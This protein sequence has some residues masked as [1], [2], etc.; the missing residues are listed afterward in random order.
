[1]VHP[2]T[3]LDPSLLV[4]TANSLKAIAH[5]VRLAMVELLKD[6][7]KLT[8]TE[9]YESLGLEQAVTSQH[10]SIL[11]DKNIL[12]SQRKGKHTFYSLKHPCVVDV[13][14]MILNT[15]ADDN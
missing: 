1:M 15:H 13:I 10:L 6:G 8:V 11:R 4:K 7:G 14:Q 2:T 5:P 12:K 9:I 3:D